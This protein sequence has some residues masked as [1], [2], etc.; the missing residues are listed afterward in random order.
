MPLLSSQWAA[1]ETAFGYDI[2]L[3]VGPQG[4]G[5]FQRA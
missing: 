5:P 3:G 2:T 4:L 1:K